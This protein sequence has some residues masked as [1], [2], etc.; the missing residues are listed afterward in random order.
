[1]TARGPA[2]AAVCARHLGTSQASCSFHLRQLAKYGFVEL[3]E[4]SEDRR[5]RPWRLVDVEQEWS[6]VDGGPAA[7][8][9]DRVFI[10]R[11][12]E[13]M[14]TWRT[15]SANMPEPWRRAAFLGGLTVPVT[16]T[17]LEQIRDQL[18]A[19]VSPYVARLDDPSSRPVDSRLVRLLLSAVPLTHLDDFATDPLRRRRPDA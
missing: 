7:D 17:E 12:A 5:E 11:E 1:M 18:M 19:V 13:R 3:A 15:A 16:V 6:A 10:E 8:Q 2:T 4:V 9:L 14:Q